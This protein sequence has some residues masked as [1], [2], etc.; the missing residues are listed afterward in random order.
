[1]PSSH[2]VLSPSASERW[3]SCPASIAMAELV[4]P[5][6]ESGYAAEGTA[7]HGLA[8]LK[9]RWSFGQISE[10]DYVVERGKWHA[11]QRRALAEHGLELN[12][13]LDDMDEHTDAYV[14]LL[15]ELAAEHPGTVVMFEQR[16]DTGVP[17]CW[18][19]SDAVLLSLSHIGIVDFKY[20]TGV[21]V[22]AVGN[23]QLRLY[24]CGA[25]SAFGDLL[26]TTETVRMTVHQPR[27]SHVLHETITPAELLAWR[28]EVIRVAEVALSPGAPFGP[29][30]SACRW[31]PAA[32]RCKAQLEEVFGAGDFY[33]DPSLLPPEDIAEALGKV[34]LI[35][36]WINALDAAA[37]AMAYSEGTEIP[38]YKVV[39]SSG[40]RYVAD[41][42]GAISALLGDGFELDQVAT[43][44][45]VV[46][47]I[48]ALEKLVG[49]ARFAELLGPYVRKSEGRPSIVHESDKRQSINPT[50]Q[51]QKDFA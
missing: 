41:A 50:N 26:G 5:G 21:A 8:E 2:A 1:M 18:G 11:E 51:A 37:L 10:V 13:L 30:E 9:G 14:E 47:G 22:E 27:L 25:L 45:P 6:V 24:G 48:G 42:D 19:T 33:S 44:K 4:P 28:D 35:R 49:K 29:S 12:E 23:S 15:R 39:L 16:L 43:S 32:G 36:D 46:K 20:G 34:K 31:C 38:G 17:N 40:K 3:I 7:A